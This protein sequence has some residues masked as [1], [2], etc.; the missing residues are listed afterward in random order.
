MLSMCSSF[1]LSSADE[2]F[3]ASSAELSDSKDSFSDVDFELLGEFSD[4][5]SVESKESFFD[6]IKLDSLVLPSSTGGSKKVDKT[7]I[8]K[9]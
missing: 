5:C 4:F 2:D 8:E 6:S 3:L 9:D 1:E 7:W